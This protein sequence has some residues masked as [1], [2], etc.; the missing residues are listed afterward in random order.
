MEW[1][2]LR[3]DLR[4]SWTT[5]AGTETNLERLVSYLKRSK[6]TVSSLWRVLNLLNAVR[7]GYSGQGRAGSPEDK[8]VVRLRNQVS[9]RY[10]SAKLRVFEVPTRKEIEKEWSK[11]TTFQQAAIYLDLRDRLNK[12]GAEHRQE[13]A[14]F[15]KILE[16]LADG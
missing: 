4:G 2:A 5:L 11:L 16:E 3:V 15:V 7:M 14:W 12:G 6:F 13:L 10:H 8:L 1:Q 9:R